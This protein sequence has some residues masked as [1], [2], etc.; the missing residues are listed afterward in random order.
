MRDL[1]QLCLDAA[2]YQA[3]EKII[4]T[5]TRSIN[6]FSPRDVD[7]FNEKLRLLLQA[8]L[9]WMRGTI[10]N[11]SAAIDQSFTLYDELA[12][13]D[14]Q[15]SILNSH[16]STMAERRYDLATNGVNRASNLQIAKGLLEPLADKGTLNL[17]GVMFESWV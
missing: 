17:Q 11:E 14:P 15:Q 3:A 13:L 12:R 16:R 10:L 1:A 9:L 5:L 7:A 6:E 2:N 4:A 8:E